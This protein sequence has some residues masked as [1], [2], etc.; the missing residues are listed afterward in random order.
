MSREMVI[1]FAIDAPS[2]SSANA[3]LRAL[4]QAGYPGDVFR[5]E[6]SARWS[7]YCSITM[8]PNYHQLLRTFETLNQLTSPHGGKADGWGTLG[9]GPDSQT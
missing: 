9:N 5:S 2:E 3:C 7:V 8:V 6:G 4:N 1:D